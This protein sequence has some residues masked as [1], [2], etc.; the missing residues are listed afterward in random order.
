MADDDV[1]EPEVLPAGDQ[2]GEV[3]VVQAGGVEVVRAQD[4]AALDVAV[5]TAL[6]HPRD[7][8]AFQADLE[9]WATADKETAEGCNYAFT[10]GGKNISGPSIRFAELLEM[11]YG[12]IRTQDR[13]IENGRDGD[14]VV[15]E[16]TAFDCQRNVA[17]RAEVHL[18]IVDKHGKRFSEDLIQTTMQRALQTAHR[19]AIIRLVPKPL[20]KAAYAKAMQVAAGKGKEFTKSRDGAFEHLAKL[21]ADQARV[22][23]FL[24][25]ESL[26]EVT[27]EDVV[28]LRQCFAR[29]RA[30]E[31]L[32]EVLP[33]RAS[34]AGEAQAAAAKAAEAVAGSGSGRAGGEGGS[35]DA[36]DASEGAEGDPPEGSSESPSSESEPEAPATTAPEAA[37]A[38]EREPEQ[39]GFDA[40]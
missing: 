30:G 35:G 1:R 5:E 34:P 16:A 3:M 9:A 37:P 6:A 25:R 28:A 7:I 33:H 4:R 32:D 21:G 26:D 17:R 39:G 8:K 29:L 10:R 12:N 36:P 18:R 2:K 23:G 31:K 14:Y 38:A 20:W 11:A 40:F 24:G 19:N 13:I 27:P 15:A 22:L